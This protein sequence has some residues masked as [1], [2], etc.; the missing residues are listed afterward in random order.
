MISSS[1]FRS[2]LEADL[3]GHLEYTWLSKM[4]SLEVEGRNRPQSSWSWSSSWKMPSFVSQMDVTKRGT[5][6]SWL[7]DAHLSV[8]VSKLELFMGS[9]LFI[10]VS[11]PAGI[12]EG[13]SDV[14]S[15]P[16]H[17]ISP[18]LSF[19]ASASSSVHLG[20]YSCLFSAV[21]VRFQMKIYLQDHSA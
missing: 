7:S 6:A 8:L 18:F 19:S 21:V 14:L 16:Q 9:F 3:K 2:S 4:P 5:W 1:C 12:T 15:W 20:K 17:C 11:E 10:Q 13:Q